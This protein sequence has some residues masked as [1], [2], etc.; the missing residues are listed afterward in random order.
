MWQW[1]EY[2]KATVEINQLLLC[3][4]DKSTKH[5]KNRNSLVVSQK[6]ASGKRKVRDL[7]VGYRINFATEHGPEIQFSYKGMGI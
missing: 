4:V 5:V 6:Y 7:L 1:F 2:F 3:L